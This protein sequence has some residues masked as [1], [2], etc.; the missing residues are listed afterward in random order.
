MLRY[1]PSLRFPCRLQEPG[2]FFLGKDKPAH[3]L[4]TSAAKQLICPRAALVAVPRSSRALGSDFS[5][6]E[7]PFCFSVHQSRAFLCLLCPLSCHWTLNWEQWMPSW[8]TSLDRGIIHI[9]SLCFHRNPDPP[10]PQHS[11]ERLEPADRVSSSCPPS[12]PGNSHRAPKRSPP[13][14]STRFAARTLTAQLGWGPMARDG[15]RPSL[16]PQ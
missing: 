16:T 3:S 8:K 12:L 5:A 1:H 11:S 15:C 14:K 4:T 7:L 13:Q 9:L 2:I 6:G 10:K